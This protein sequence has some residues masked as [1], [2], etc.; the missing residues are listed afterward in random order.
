MPFNARDAVRA[1]PPPEDPKSAHE[2][3]TIREPR[4]RSGTFDAIFGSNE[5]EYRART[6]ARGVAPPAGGVTSSREAS[7]RPNQRRGDHIEVD[8]VQVVA[9]RR[10]T[11]LPR[12]IQPATRDSPAPRRT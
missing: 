5:V 2:Q 12:G 8:P 3:S 4:S 1:P 7:T 10:T 6:T 11:P 9:T